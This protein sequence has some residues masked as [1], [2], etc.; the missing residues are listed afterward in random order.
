MRKHFLTYLSLST[1]SVAQP[2]FDL[3]GKNLTVFSAAK[4]SRWEVLLFLLALLFGPAVVAVAVDRF[5]AMFGPKVNEAVRLVLIGAFSLLTGLAVARWAGLSG[6]VPYALLAAAT[7]V[8]IPWAFDRWRAVREWSRWLAVLSLALGAT[9]FVQLRPLIFPLADTKAD[10]TVANKDLSVFMVVMDEF[11]LYALLGPDG[12]INAE[13]WPGFA[14]LANQSTWYRDAL[15]VS[16]FTHQAV[17]AVLASSRPVRDGGPF[18]YSYPHNI[19]T[20]YA[21]EMKVAATEPV[22]SLCPRRVCGGDADFGTGVSA[23][24]LRRFMKDVSIVYGQRVLPPTL[25]RRLPAVDQGWG[26]FAAVRDKFKQQLHDQVFSQRDAVVNGAEAF[27]A[28]AEP[29][30]KVVHA[31]LPHAPWRLTPDGR[32]APLSPEIGTQNPEDE[33]GTRD[34]YQAFLHQLAATDAAV[35]RAMETIKASGKWDSTMFVLTADHGISFLP[36]LPQRNTDFTDLEQ[37]EDIYR[38]PMFVKY[39][40]QVA[41]RADDC[42]V[43]NLDILPTVNAVLGTQSGWK[44][45]GMSVRDGCPTRGG[46]EVVAATGEKHTFTSGFAAARE[47]ADYYAMLVPNTGPVSRIAAVGQSAGLV[48]Q[49]VSSVTQSPLVSSWVL[50]QRDAFA[51]IDGRPGSTVPAT[52]TGTVTLTGPAVEGTEGIIAVDGIAAGVLGELSGQDGEVRFTAILDI[53]RLGAGAHTVELFVRDE[54]GTV[55]RVGP[56]A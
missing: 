14:A 8:L 44:F 36:T 29:M 28:S 17:P 45:D 19:F 37:S 51:A 35:S 30:V 9:T 10:A 21:D 6:D 15:A 22:T 20:L 49:P 12:T 13:R 50:K 11:P 18:L 26:G 43:T 53:A 39:P 40:G 31:L 56:P 47:R 25:R 42:P 2:V 38:V 4:L 48:G 34:T 1:V 54:N 55:T 3:Y 5:S 52:V 23:T 16:N 24:R 7:A 33:D 32:V 46:R 41:G 27:A